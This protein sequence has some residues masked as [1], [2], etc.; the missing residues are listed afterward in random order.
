MVQPFIF[1]HNGCQNRLP[2]PWVASSNL[3]ARSSKIKPSR[4]LLG[5]LFVF[6]ANCGPFGW[7][8]INYCNKYH[9]FSVIH[10]NR[11]RE[12]WGRT[13]C[14][15][16][17][18]LQSPSRNYKIKCCYEADFASP[19]FSV[20]RKYPTPAFGGRF[21]DGSVGTDILLLSCQTSVSLQKS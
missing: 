4:H 6:A 15:C 8:A 16:R 5:R 1:L 19:C 17:A 13:F 9:E 20:R 14:F 3:V 18:K 7:K 12:A 2:K 10:V 21:F 11:G